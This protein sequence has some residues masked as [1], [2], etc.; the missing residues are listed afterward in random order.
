MDS[1]GLVPKP[2][3][4]T[5]TSNPNQISDMVSSSGR[6]KCL[7][8]M[9]VRVS[10]AREKNNTIRNWKLIEYRI[11]IKTANAELVS[12]TIGY[13]L[14]IELLHFEHFPFKKI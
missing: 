11:P 3:F 2:K 8:S 10:R 5:L 7:I 6:I 14:D 4:V 13:C 12:S 1:D 9:I